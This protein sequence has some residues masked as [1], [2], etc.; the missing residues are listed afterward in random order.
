[1]IT[2]ARMRRD[3][4]F[5]VIRITTGLPQWR[6]LLEHCALNS[7]RVSPQNIFNTKGMP[8]WQSRLGHC[9]LNAHCV[10]LWLECVEVESIR[11]GRH[12][13]SAVLGRAVRE[14][15]RCDEVYTVELGVICCQ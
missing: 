5:V 1:M 12:N 6:N 7:R 15:D 11:I 3:I 10:Q 4:R 2:S 9:T 14:S 13:E 8:Q